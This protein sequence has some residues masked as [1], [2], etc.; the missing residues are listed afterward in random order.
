MLS[1]APV[2]RRNCTGRPPF[3]LPGKFKQYPGAKL[4]VCTTSS[5]F[6]VRA[7]SHLFALVQVDLGGPSR[8]EPATG[9][10]G[11]HFLT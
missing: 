5:G 1:L 9:W 10:E 6:I 4:L 3:T 2:L 11:S 8:I 7:A